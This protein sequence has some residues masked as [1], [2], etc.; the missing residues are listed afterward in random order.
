MNYNI[1]TQNTVGYK[2]IIRNKKSQDYM[3]HKV[4]KNGII[5]AIAD[6][7]G[8]ERCKYSHKGAKFACE[9]CVE[10]LEEIYESIN[11][12]DNKANKDTLINNILLTQYIEKKIQSKWREKVY[13]HHI[14]KIEN[15]Y[16]IDYIAYGTTLIGSLITED[17]NIYIQIG[18]GNILISERS[19]LNILKYSK[20]NKRK[21]IVNSMYLDDAYEYIDVK[22]KY[23][24]PKE[25]RSIVLFS[26][27]YTN[28][29]KTYNELIDTTY[30]TIINYNKN[31]FSRY[32]IIKNYNK[33]LEYLTIN[34]SKDDIS[35]IF[36]I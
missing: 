6:G 13:N 16:K 31:V 7:H 21:S 32:N 35:I 8:I 18:D 19:R 12:E 34:K 30:N 4:Y 17:L 25:K 33:Y 3:T 28:S 22:L 11:E 15:V 10:V 29:F 36:L 27:G 14:K 20:K 24:D 23:N 1:L 26:D 5:V 2:N 9:S